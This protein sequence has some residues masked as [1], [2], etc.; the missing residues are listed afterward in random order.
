MQILKIQGNILK[1]KYVALIIMGVFLLAAILLSVFLY[2]NM[3][4]AEENELKLEDYVK[5]QQV[6]KEKEAKE[7]R[8]RLASL[9]DEKFIDPDTSLGDDVL[10]EL[11]NEEKNKIDFI[12][13]VETENPWDER[14]SE[15]E[16]AETLKE[17]NFEGVIPR[18]PLP[19]SGGNKIKRTKGSM[20]IPDLGES[21]I[22]TVK[23]TMSNSSS[24][25]PGEDKIK[26]PNS[27]NSRGIIKE[28][29]KFTPEK[30]QYN[31]LEPVLVNPGDFIDC[32][33]NNKVIRRDEG[34]FVSAMVTTDCYDSNGYYVIFPRGTF[35]YGYS[36][37]GQ[38]AD[39]FS[40]AFDGLEFPNG[41]NIK[42]ISTFSKGHSLD[43]SEGID[44]KTKTRFF[45]K[46]GYSLIFG[47]LDGVVQLLSSP[48]NGIF[49]NANNSFSDIT[50]EELRS[51]TNIQPVLYLNAGQRLKIRFTKQFYISPYSSIYD[52]VGA[53]N[54]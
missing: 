30:I 39:Y 33:L 54:E 25:G 2:D 8:E 27:F 6:S 47:A 10:R 40:F 1:K 19:Q 5:E 16:V 24:P 52:G 14:G 51:K 26:L 38:S 28:K 29:T 4:A 32:V 35:V 43:G 37:P 20:I 15:K 9:R 53:S 3:E 12:P 49:G 17:L 21:K 7:N 48:V 13:E 50:R 44:G 11:E 34:V 22:T 45:K 18:E 46:Y 36:Q 31:P 42:L 41:K 23:H